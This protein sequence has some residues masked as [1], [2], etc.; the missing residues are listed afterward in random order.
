M[1]EE[2]KEPQKEVNNF[3]ILCAK[4]TK[5]DL[6]SIQIGS[7]NKMPV[8]IDGCP[9]CEV[10]LTNAKRVFKEAVMELQKKAAELQKVEE[11]GII[12]PAMAIPKNV[13]PFRK[14]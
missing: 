1:D 10:I 8:F 5:D 11:K 3:C 14:K 6:K 13:F 2:K 12:I 7:I 4:H 9:K